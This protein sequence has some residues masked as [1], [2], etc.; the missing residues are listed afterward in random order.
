MTVSA[1]NEILKE[2]NIPED[3]ELMSDSGWECGATKMNG[4]YYNEDAKIIVFTQSGSRY[5]HYYD[6]KDWKQLFGVDMGKGEN[7]ETR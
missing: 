6:Q 4:I 5:D 2:N 7:D 1:L 3:V